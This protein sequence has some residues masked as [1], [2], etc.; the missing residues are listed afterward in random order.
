VRAHLRPSDPRRQEF[1]RVACALGFQDPTV[2]S[3]PG[4]DV[5]T[6]DEKLCIVER[7]RRKIVSIVRAAS[8]AALREQVR[9]RSFR[10]VVVVTAICVATLA[11]A[12][13]VIGLL[14]PPLVPLCFAPQELGRATVVCPTGQSIPFIPAGGQPQDGIPT[15]DIDDV[16]EE[17]ADPLD[18]VVVELIGLTAAAIA[19]AAAIRGIRGSSERIGLPASLA[20]L[21]LPTG[22]LTAFLG[23]L[24]MRGQFVPGLTA[25]DTSAQIL[26]WAL[27]FGYAQQLFTRFVD[28]QGQTV[29]NDVRRESGRRAEPG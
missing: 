2:P 26:A 13:S 7:E 23:L 18:I 20:T 24:L 10:N 21:K 1:E 3:W 6:A 5:S 28:Q 16:I 15:R 12:V 25:L 4:E 9:L 22:A 19:S 29:L 17:T 27:V 14:R 11:V 8:S